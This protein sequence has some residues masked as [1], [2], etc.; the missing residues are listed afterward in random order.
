V[1]RK[2]GDEGTGRLEGL[3]DEKGRVAD[4]R[5]YDSSG[6][7]ILDQSART[8]VEKWLFEPGTKDGRVTQMWVRV[9]IRFKLNQ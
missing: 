4:L 1:A 9:P 7:E 2:R 8:S 5:V 6:C 3:V